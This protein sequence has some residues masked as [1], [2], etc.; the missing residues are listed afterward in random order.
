MINKGAN[1][2]EILKIN[3]SKYEKLNIR[4]KDFEFIAVKK[5]LTSLG[6]ALLLLHIFDFYCSFIF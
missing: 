2:W 1:Y 5:T 6:N 4:C 3:I